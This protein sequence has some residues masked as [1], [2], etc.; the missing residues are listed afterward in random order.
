M[1]NLTIG[2]DSQWKVRSYSTEKE[3]KAGIKKTVPQMS[4]GT[5]I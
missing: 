5:H 4:Y 1:K 2:V 3:E